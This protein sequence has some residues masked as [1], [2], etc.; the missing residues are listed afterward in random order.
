MRRSGFLSTSTPRLIGWRTRELYTGAFGS[1]AGST[2]T[3]GTTNTGG[4]GTW[5]ANNDR[6]SLCRW[7]MS[8]TGTAQTLTFSIDSS[9]GDTTPVKGLIYA[10]DGPSSAAGTLVAVGS[11][12]VVP[13]S[14]GA[15]SYVS[16]FAGES[17]TP[18]DYWI[19]VVSDGFAAIF[20]SG[21]PITSGYHGLWN[22][23]VSYASPPS[24]LSSTAPDATYD[25]SLAAYVTYEL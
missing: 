6:A 16:N 8:D 7:T 24:D 4:G 19:G 15:S 17:L 20:D 9:I 21:E 22:G 23:S 11:V 2:G 10:A 5:G 14:Q 3:L 13:A 18:G 12:V 25:N 1:P